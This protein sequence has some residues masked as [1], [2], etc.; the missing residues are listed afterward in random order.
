MPS[1]PTKGRQGHPWPVVAS[2]AG[3]G[4]F[5]RAG[6]PPA[7]WASPF[8]TAAASGPPPTGSQH[9]DNGNGGN[10]LRRLL[11]CVFP[12]LVRGAGTPCLVAGRPPALFS[13]VGEG[14]G[15]IT[16]QR[17]PRGHNQGC[18]NQRSRR[19]P[20]RLATGFRSVPQVSECWT[21][22]EKV[23]RRSP[24]YDGH[25]WPRL[26]RHALALF[27][28]ADGGEAAGARR[29]RRTPARGRRTADGGSRTAAAGPDVGPVSGGSLARL[30]RDVE[31]DGVASGAG[32]R[33]FAVKRENIGGG[34]ATGY[35]ECPGG[36][37]QVLG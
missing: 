28:R 36:Q 7:L 15:A 30:R 16:A 9:T 20:R 17:G 26:A 31:F 14:G 19:Q 1:P 5:L 32:V 22:M 18:G 12:F 6:P 11:F 21:R 23:V 25:R 37:I 4:S 2:A 33:F 34:D 8:G 35:M 29:D 3:P 24:N 10:G 27:P 13:C